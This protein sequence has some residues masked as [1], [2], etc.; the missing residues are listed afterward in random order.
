MLAHERGVNGTAFVKCWAF[1]PDGK[2]V[3]TGSRCRDGSEGRI[4]VW[5]AATGT[6]AARFREGEKERGGLGN[7]KGLA[8][9]MDGKT[10]LFDAGEF[11]IDG[12]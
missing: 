8:F 5:D 12:K 7:V 2:L 9:S 4:Y 11:E 3:A 10:V 1:S 6:L